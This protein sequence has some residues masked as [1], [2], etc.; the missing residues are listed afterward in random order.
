VVVQRAGLIPPSSACAA[1]CLLVTL[2]IFTWS[3]FLPDCCPTAVPKPLGTQRAGCWIR[4]E[5]LV[6]GA[7]PAGIEP[8]TPSLPWNRQEPLCGPPFS[9]VTPDREGR[10]YRFSL[11][12]VMRSLASYRLSLRR[13]IPDQRSPNSAH[14]LLDR[15]FALA[16]RIS[17]RHV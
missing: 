10:S 1:I 6:C 15:P 2:G 13:A 9:Q 14:T 4:S 11:G 12:K 3:G 5:L 8:A 17:R 7:P 16:E